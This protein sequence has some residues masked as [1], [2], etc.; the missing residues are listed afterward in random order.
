MSTPWGLTCIYIILIKYK[1][2]LPDYL[3]ITK[4]PRKEIIILFQQGCSPQAKEAYIY[5]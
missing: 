4:I 2:A 3:K 1:Q 5:I